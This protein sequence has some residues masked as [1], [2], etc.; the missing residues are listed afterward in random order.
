MKHI[1]DD[2]YDYLG[3]FIIYP[4]EE[5]R[6]AHV[7]FIA[8]TYLMGAFKYTPRLAVLSAEKQSGKTR[9][10]EITE[11]LSQNPYS[12]VSPSPA[13]L[14]TL[15]EAET[16]RPTVLIDEVDRLYEKKDTSDITAL[17]N[18]GFMA[19]QTVPRV[20]LDRNGVRTV[21]R[22]RAFC[23]LLIAGIDRQQI[24]DTILDRSIIIRMKRRKANETVEPFRDVDCGQEG[25]D[26]KQRLADW[27]NDVLEGAKR[28]RPGMPEGI[29]DRNADRWE[30]LF[31]VAD[32]AD[33][34]HRGGWGAKARDA[35]LA[36]VRQ[37]KEIE[38][39]NGILLLEHIYHI[40]NHSDIYRQALQ[41]D[42][43]KISTR[44]LLDE[45]FKVDE[46][47]WSYIN[48]RPLDERGLARMLGVYGIKPEKLRIG[49]DTPRGYYKAAFHDAWERYPP[50]P[51]PT[52]GEAEQMEL[53]DISHKRTRSDAVWDAWVKEAQPRQHRVPGLPLPGE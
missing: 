32:M 45:L 43:E 33:V 46:S 35:A 25:R 16:V 36:F 47:P 37:E 1:L 8:H 13:S 51:R 34:P 22:F 2:I 42:S 31:T 12:F 52:P 23:P 17:L 18:T 30:P 6:V 44:E 29:E 19:G 38:P 26:L 9:L 48:G 14:H 24:P 27:A 21:R 40:F 3:R 41:R 5:A 50:R 49:N 15:I 10:L 53:P 28:H 7:L 20:E 11:L 39:S 4:S